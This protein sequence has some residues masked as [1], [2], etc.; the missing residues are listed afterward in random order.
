MQL[1]SVIIDD[2]L[3]CRESLNSLLATLHPEVEVLGTAHSV[4]SGFQLIQN[5]RPDILFLDIELP[6]GTGFDLLERL[7]DQEL[8][9]VFVT[10]HNQYAYLAFEFAAMAYLVKP[11][12]TDKLTRA[13][14]QA[15]ER[16][17]RCTYTQKIQDLQ[18]VVDNYRQQKL[19][20][21]LAISNSSGIHYLPIEEITHLTVDQG[22]TEVHQHNGNR[23]TVSANL[24]EYERRFAAFD[25]FLKVHRSYLINLHYVS[26][27]LH[28]GEVLLRNGK[29]VPVSQR[30]QEELKER[31]NRMSA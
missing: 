12:A 13:I 30:H 14:Q 15:R 16:F 7:K 4:D 29:S 28:E 20:S 22:C 26:S 25:H 18:E 9:T 17:E 10:A 11:I 5:T 23:V 21:R 19:P 24:I 8:A 2:E 3:H 27:Y 31:L 6:D 1:T